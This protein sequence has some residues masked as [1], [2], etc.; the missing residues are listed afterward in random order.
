MA[1]EPRRVRPPKRQ[2]SGTGPR[3]IERL[4]DE[5]PFQTKQKALMFAAAVGAHFGRRE[6]LGATEEPIRW[7]I[8]QNNGDDAF[9]QALGVAE[10]EGLEVLAD[11]EGE[12]YVSLF[13]EYA[14]GGL[15]YLEQHVL[16]QPV[17]L[18]DALVD[19]LLQM[20]RGGDRQ[21]G[22]LENIAP[23]QLDALGL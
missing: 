7:Q 1:V 15:A 9:I 20:R 16:N 8:F 14:N 17:D 3:T 21:R 4:V 19:L 23:G 10:T 12:A 5:G 6:P 11:E 18:L 2:P 13:E 22:G